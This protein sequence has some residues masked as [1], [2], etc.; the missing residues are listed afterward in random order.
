MVSKERLK[1][2]FVNMV[3]VDRPSK[4]EYEMAKCLVSYLKEIGIDAKFY[5]QM[6]NDLYSRIA[7]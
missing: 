7:F 1:E 6:G 5:I 4:K 3:K 2:R